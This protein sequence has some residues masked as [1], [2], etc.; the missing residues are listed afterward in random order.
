MLSEGLGFSVGTELLFL[1]MGSQSSGGT[2][3]DAG[4]Q[5]QM[6]WDPA[7]QTVLYT[8]DH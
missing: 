8:G 2:R 6:K 5:I 1:R 7:V 3:G 4:E